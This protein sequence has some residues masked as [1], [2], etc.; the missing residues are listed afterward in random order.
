MMRSRAADHARQPANKL[1]R[2]PLAWLGVFLLPLLAVTAGHSQEQAEPQVPAFRRVFIPADQI[3][4]YASLFVGSQ[5]QTLRCV[6]R[7]PEEIE[8]LLKQVQQAK[9][10]D[11]DE[12]QLR[13]RRAEYQARLDKSQLV[14]GTATLD[15]ESPVQLP[16]LQT[17]PACGLAIRR[18]VWPG[19]P[20]E[21]AIFGLRQ[22]GSWGVLVDRSGPLKLQWSRQG[23]ATAGEAVQFELHL[24]PAPKNLLTLELP[25]DRIPTIEGA[26]RDAPRPSPR[27]GYFLW[28]FRLGGR[29][30]FSLKVAPGKLSKNREPVTLV[31]ETFN[32]SFA[33]NG[34]ELSG[35]FDLTTIAGQR[36]KFQLLLDPGMRIV[37]ARQDTDPLRWSIE[38]EEGNRQL[39]TLHLPERTPDGHCIITVRALLPLK[40][41]QLWELPLM[42]PHGAH[43]QEGTT[44]L[45]IPDPFILHQLQATQRNQQP[46]CQQVESS[47]LPQPSGGESVVVQ[48]AMPEAGLK[49]YLTK[50]QVGLHV[51][52]LANLVWTP[53]QV[54]A[55][56]EV[57]LSSVAGKV[58]QLEGQ[59]SGSWVI[60]S[61]TTEPPELLIDWQVLSQTDRS[62]RLTLQFAKPL[63]SA[64]PLQLVITGRLLRPPLGEKLP[65]EELQPIWFAQAEQSEY[66]LGLSRQESYRL[67]Y[68]PGTAKQAAE[69]VPAELKERFAKEPEFFFRLESR[70]NSAHI[71][72]T[73]EQSSYQAQSETLLTLT[74][75]TI[76]RETLCRILPEADHPLDR[77]RVIVPSGETYWALLESPTDLQFSAQQQATSAALQED[78]LTVWQLRFDPPC[79]ASVTF[80]AKQ[81]RATDQWPRKEFPLRFPQAEDH[82][83]TLAVRTFC[84][85][86]IDIRNVGL[87]KVTTLPSNDPAM[88]TSATYRL[89][90]SQATAHP[91]NPFLILAQGPSE[92]IPQWVLW[93][94]D[95]ESRYHT[96]GQIDQLA[97]CWIENIG[98]G[99]LEIGFPEAAELSGLWLNGEVVAERVTAGK[100][101]VALPLDRRFH[102]LQFTWQQHGLPLGTMSKPVLPEL[103]FPVDPVRHRWKVW[104]PEN[105]SVWHAPPAWRSAPEVSWLQ[106]WFGP[107]RRP[108]TNRSSAAVSDA[109]LK[110]ALDTIQRVEEL[111]VRPSGDVIT[112]NDLLDRANRVE[113]GSS[114]PLWIDLPA[115]ESLGIRADTLLPAESTP[116]TTDVSGDLAFVVWQDR[117]ILTSQVAVQPWVS[118]WQEYQ[119]GSQQ[120]W[121]AEEQA[122]WDAS[123]GAL[124]PFE[125][126][127]LQ[128]QSPWS[129]QSTQEPSNHPT[130][131]AALGWKAAEFTPSSPGELIVVDQW[132]CWSWQW[133]CGLL[134]LSIVL[135]WPVAWW[136]G[137]IVL[138]SGTLIACLLV[139][140]EYTF[141]TTA[142]NLGLLL[143]CGWRVFA[144]RRPKKQ[145][146]TIHPS[147]APTPI[148]TAVCLLFG[149]GLLCLGGWSQAQT[150]QQT[151]YPLF[152]P[153]DKELK[154]LSGKEGGKYWVPID[155]YR[156]LR[157]QTER[158]SGQPQGML[159]QQASYQGQLLGTSEEAIQPTLN[160]V[161]DFYTFEEELSVRL[162]LRKEQLSEIPEMVILDDQSVPVSWDADQRVLQLAIASRGSH[163]LELELRP[164]TRKGEKLLEL[165][166]LPIPS[167]HLL[168]ES[169]EENVIAL[170]ARGQEVTATEYDVEL[171]PISQ[172][173]LQQTSLTQAEQT[174]GVL[175]VQQLQWLKVVPGSLVLQTRLRCQIPQGT[176][177]QLEIEVDPRYELIRPWQADELGSQQIQQLPDGTKLHQIKFRRG[178]SGSFVLEGTF[179]LKDTSG[180]GRLRL[181]EIM[182]RQAEVTGKR[183]ALALDASLTLDEVFLPTIE[184]GVFA[185]DWGKPEIAIQQVLDL[186]SADDEVWHFS[187]RPQAPTKRA[188]ERVELAALAERLELNYRAQLTSTNGVSY[189]HR[190]RLPSGFQVQA[191]TSPEEQTA[192]LRWRQQD[193][194]LSV[195][196]LRTPS[197]QQD[198]L[199]RGE[200]PWDENKR[201][202]F[203]RLRP[204]DT[205]I[206]ETEI[207]L[208]RSPEVKV[209]YDFPAQWTQQ[210]PDAVGTSTENQLRVVGTWK[211]TANPN[212]DAEAKFQLSAN[213]PVL[214]GNGVIRVLSENGQTQLQVELSIQQVSGGVVDELRLRVPQLA[215]PDQ[216]SSDWEFEFAE[217]EL[218][219]LPVQSVEGPAQVRVSWLI[220]SSQTPTVP[221][222]E[223]ID[224]PQ[225]TWWLVLP[226][227]LNEKPVAWDT[228]GLHEV[229][230]PAE[231]FPT[232]TPMVRYW[233]PHSIPFSASLRPT[234][235]DAAES[236]IWSAEYAIYRQTRDHYTGTAAFWIDPAGQSEAH[237]QLPVGCKLL[238]AQTDRRPSLL[239]SQAENKFTLHLRSNTEPCLVEL[240]FQGTAESNWQVPVFPQL[241]VQET[242]WT[243]HPIRSNPIPPE[244]RQEELAL[245]LTRWENS[246]QAIEQSST[247]ISR[248]PFA[249][250]QVR[251]LGHRLATARDV[252][253]WQTAIAADDARAQDVRASLIALETEKSE[254]L[255]DWLSRPSSQA[256]AFPISASEYWQGCP[257]RGA[258]AYG[259]WDQSKPTLEYQPTNST[260]SLPVARWAAAFAIGGLGLWLAFGLP[261]ATAQR[262]YYQWRYAFGVLV[263]LGWSAWL[264]PAWLGWLIVAVCLGGSLYNPWQGRR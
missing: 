205:T 70:G 98:T 192:K 223:L 173:Q 227:Q 261:Q 44:T 162:P 213:R 48:H 254:L 95:L 126:W 154:P 85:S 135:W 36:S 94:L 46:T 250:G 197:N 6:P 125:A 212:E 144:T 202:A 207:L 253:Q 5:G 27:K 166:I 17:L 204:V 240:V 186:G 49:V 152:I 231:L 143:G 252:V 146:I 102:R 77:L 136:R 56:M 180:I 161:L 12:Q 242:W 169:D 18:A 26:L 198:I 206:V 129:T 188:K 174:D 178:L 229:D 150:Q 97:T 163:R 76:T 215:A 121:L 31:K 132:T 141:A 45:R 195:R 111:I 74:D 59:V 104:L 259:R 189:Q 133:A 33:P 167:T 222:I 2:L 230:W 42:I 88:L 165:D 258:T 4:D 211:R 32:Y 86:E 187:V 109:T 220:P 236:R 103:A 159:W 79:Q 64:E 87:E 255:A 89:K 127:T 62:N 68:D 101:Q 177:E 71:G 14:E 34:V 233:Q 28:T 243:V 92:S 170:N 105:Y 239:R 19:D 199:I 248:S 148:S 81:F 210:N 63:R 20:D 232:E 176:F 100:L 16:R 214:S 140:E 208:L 13:I 93:Q 119:T 8:R 171:G 23:K 24:P 164:K 117:L 185:M 200:L 106:R 99:K 247:E 203:P 51:R 244:H 35:K 131:L 108:T 183:L 228:Q 134:A 168:F 9:R 53:D 201:D 69:Q 10:S 40:L 43:W 209:D 113:D 196:M 80:Q 37:A 30:Q 91:T 39:L 84:S 246:L 90:H 145:S 65:L 116:H 237:L 60:D 114:L 181:P 260:D 235:A 66:Y 124:I 219:L 107:L 226:T 47:P 54:S 120:V 194:L 41:N 11:F 15:L 225:V 257:R 25:W 139:P 245:A 67:D 160:A 96:N 157:E 175:Q 82:E 149:I 115:L 241:P 256:A 179:L 190:F 155:F 137:L 21:A 262:W 151:V 72:L 52:S 221:A 193:N 123:N 217:E 1:L 61:I 50:R 118:V 128:P 224:Q 216:I 218:L 55:A 264:T 184:P 251:P 73:P 249:S 142:I 29:H 3:E 238:L 22:D 182:V 172:L 130:S 138:S 7:E 122:P 112:W 147:P 263:G 83:A 153:V 110:Q 158:L 57:D 75:R 78:G 191:V 58:F 156:Q 38:P 234:V